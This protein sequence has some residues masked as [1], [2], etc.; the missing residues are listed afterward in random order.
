MTHGPNAAREEIQSESYV[1]WI[2]LITRSAMTFTSSCIDLR[3]FAVQGAHRFM[4][5]VNMANIVGT[6]GFIIT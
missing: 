6:V 1:A 4:K 5:A 2:L 3:T